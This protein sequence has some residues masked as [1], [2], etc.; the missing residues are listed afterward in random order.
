MAKKFFGG[1][2][3]QNESILKFGDLDSSNFIGLK[4][5]A[6]VSADFNLTLPSSI[7]SA[8]DVMLADASGNLSFGKIADANISSIS[9]SK[10]ENLTIDRALISDGSGDVSISAVTSTELAQLS[11]NTFGGS[12]S[13]DVVTIDGTQTLTGKTIDANGV[14]NVIT[15]I[16]NNEIEAGA[17]IVESKLTLDFSTASL[18][19]AINN[20]SS[21]IQNFEWQPSVLDIVLDSATVTPNSGDRYLINGFGVNDF[22]GQD[23]KIAEYNGAT[24]EFITPTTGM[25]V[26]VDDEPNSLY[27]FGGT[28]WSSKAF[29]S[30]T[31]STGLTKDGNFDIQLANAATNASGIQVASGSITLEHLN[32]FD[33]DDLSEGAANFYYTEARF[34]SSLSGKSTTDLAEGTNLYFTDARAR[35][36]A[37]AD[38]IADGVTNIAPSQNAVFDALALKQND[39]IT[40]EGDLVIGDVGGGESRLGIGTAGQVLT[41]SGST[42]VWSSPTA[43][44]KSAVVTWANGD[45]TTRAIAH[46][47]N[48]RNLIVQIFDENFETIEIDSV[49]RTDAN[50][51]TLTASSAPATSWTVLIQE[52]LN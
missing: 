25:F 9:F 7:S 28:S 36:A 48:T 19:S 46:G 24:Y 41:V 16:G 10:L 47:F 26:S 15:N 44:A 51:L 31:A 50:N 1:I 49:V 30:T 38:A 5:P 17:G 18:N 37:V 12:A 4:S 13:G 29:E 8:D 52:V 3:L 22:A 32:N 11:G 35:T 40:T 27:L 39:V 45:G 20:L 14:G 33:T 34:N 42:A 21:T 43:A 2:D 6:A 23:N